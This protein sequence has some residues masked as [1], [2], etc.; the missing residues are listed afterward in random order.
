MPWNCLKY[1]GGMKVFKKFLMTDSSSWQ[2]QRSFKKTSMFWILDLMPLSCFKTC[3]TRLKFLCS[4]MILRMFRIKFLIF[5]EP[6]TPG[7]LRKTI[8]M[9]YSMPFSRDRI[10]Q[11]QGF[12]FFLSI[13]IRSFLRRQFCPWMFCSSSYSLYDMVFI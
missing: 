11:L 12:M 3:C 9:I 13:F 7:D 8:W 1:L 10:S 4:V 6:S 2:L 5:S